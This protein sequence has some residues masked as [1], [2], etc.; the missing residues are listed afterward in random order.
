MVWR[1]L[2]KRWL[3]GAAVQLVTDVLSPPVTLLRSRLFTNAAFLWL[4][5]IGLAGLGFAFWNVVARLY[6]PES[7]GLAGAAITSINLLSTLASLGLGFAIV[8]FIRQSSGEAQ[9]LLGRSLVAVAAASLPVGLLFLASLPLW[10][11]ELQALY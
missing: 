9:L 5:E 1:L 10:S 7:V 11:E 3:S 2:G 4:G 6:P 8:R